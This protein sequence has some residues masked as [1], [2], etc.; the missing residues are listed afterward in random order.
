MVFS[1]ELLDVPVLASTVAVL[2]ASLVV[3][4]H[5][6]AHVEEVLVAVLVGHPLDRLAVA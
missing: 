5:V 6:D 3:L 1:L 4:V 2:G